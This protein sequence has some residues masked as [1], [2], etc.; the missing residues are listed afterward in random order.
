M[1]TMATTG[2]V[3]TG[4]DVLEIS[5]FPEHVARRTPAQARLDM[6]L[7][8]GGDERIWLDPV[9][10]RNRHGA[11]ASPAAEELWFASAEGHLIP[12]FNLS[13]APSYPLRSPHN[14]LKYW[15]FVAVFSASLSSRL[16]SPPLAIACAL[17]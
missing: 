13:H 16:L 8:S 2:R 17:L 3:Q 9:T 6:M 15:A 7:V 1:A 4:A 10:R 14:P 11:P 5:R 12:F